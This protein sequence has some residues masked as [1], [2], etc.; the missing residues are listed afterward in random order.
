[1]PSHTPPPDGAPPRLPPPRPPVIPAKAGTYPHD[2]HSREGGISP[3]LDDAQS[4]EIPLSLQGERT[5]RTRRV[6]VLRTG[7]VAF[8]HSCVGRNPFGASAP[9]TGRR[10]VSPNPHAPRHS[11]ESGNLPPPA[12]RPLT[13]IPAKA[14]ISP[15]VLK[16]RSFGAKKCSFSAHRALIRRSKSAQTALK[17]CSPPPDGADRIPVPSGAP[18]PNP[19]KPESPSQSEPV[20]SPSPSRSLNYDTTLLRSATPTAILDPN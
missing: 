7:R 11:R 20:S 14:G 15:P 3:L 6:R 5:P 2:R 1:M 8:R 13:V 12:E 17:K 19:R 10:P 9:Q 18:R 16:R 4:A